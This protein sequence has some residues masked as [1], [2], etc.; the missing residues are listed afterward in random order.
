MLVEKTGRLSVG[1]RALS[2]AACLVVAETKAL[3]VGLSRD[4]T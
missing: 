2:L 3:I 1:W 4:L